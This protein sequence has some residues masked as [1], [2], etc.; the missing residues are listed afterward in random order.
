[1]F[2]IFFPLAVDSIWLFDSICQENENED[3]WT[4]LH[5]V[6]RFMC[7]E[8]MHIFFCFAYLHVIFHIHSEWHKY[9]RTLHS[10]GKLHCCRL[11]VAFE[12]RWH[13]TAL[14][15]LSQRSAPNSSSILGSDWRGRGHYLMSLTVQTWNKSA[16]L[17]SS[18][19]RLH[20]LDLNAFLWTAHWQLNAYFCKA[21]VI[22]CILKQIT[23]GI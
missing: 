16:D 20:A 22:K 21:L 19:P 9:S 23:F 17:S 10:L 14:P 11:T 15:P 6:L 13:I 18:S 12:A 3:F 2:N 8:G 7:W 4:W 1:M 5:P